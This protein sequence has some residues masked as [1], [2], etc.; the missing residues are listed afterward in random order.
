VVNNEVLS[1][2]VDTSDAWIQKRTGIKQ[3][4]IASDNE[5]SFTMGLAAAQACLAQSG[6]AAS[7]I[8]CVLVASCTP[9]QAYPSLACK[10]AA[11]LGVGNCFALDINAACSGA[12]YALDLLYAQMFR[13]EGWETV[14]I[15]GVDTMTRLV[16]WRDRNSCV[17]FGD[18]AGAM[19]WTRDDKPGLQAVR[20]SA[21]GAGGALLYAQEIPSQATRERVFAW[22][23]SS[24]TT[25]MQGKEV[26]KT[27]VEKMTE[28]SQEVLKQA[29]LE[30]QAVDWCVPHQ[31][32]ARILQAVCKQ[33]GLPEE[34]LI[35][36]IGLHANTSAASV[37]LALDW[38]LKNGTMKP[39]DTVLCNAFGAG[40]TW[41][42]AVIT[43]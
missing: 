34:R 12:L 18:G 24:A 41:G 19:L 31:A 3:R 22:D 23:K 9:P 20:C 25:I 30:L 32:N 27:A 42:A 7:A 1:E 28:V 29:Q 40:F 6:R 11:E 15:V 8:D 17:L 35:N 21:D 5:S 26:F 4:C 36:T 33:L 10:I 39:G 13:P 14:L 2:K 38:G 37:P 16:D 43:L